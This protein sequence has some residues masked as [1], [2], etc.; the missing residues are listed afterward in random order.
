MI[1][2]ASNEDSEKPET[3]KSHRVINNPGIV[4]NNIKSLTVTQNDKNIDKENPNQ[5]KSQ[6]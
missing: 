1:Q 6:N 2:I 3:I 4:I 5:N